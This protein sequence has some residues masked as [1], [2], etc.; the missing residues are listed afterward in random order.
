M[1]D[2]VLQLVD[3][4]LLP[5]LVTSLKTGNEEEQEITAKL[6]WTLCFDEQIK[7]RV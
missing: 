1:C 5:L 6:T 3:E 7:Q 2:Y 4:G